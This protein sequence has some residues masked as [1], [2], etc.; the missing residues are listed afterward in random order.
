MSLGLNQLT[1]TTEAFWEIIDIKNMEKYRY[2]KAN[3][4]KFL[5]QKGHFLTVDL[6]FLENPPDFTIPLSRLQT[7][8]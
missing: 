5:V 6:G 7:I 3:L 2:F 1:G 8:I 4:V